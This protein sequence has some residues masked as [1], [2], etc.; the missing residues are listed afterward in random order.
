MAKANLAK[1]KKGS[2]LLEKQGPLQ[3]D[4][5]LH[6]SDGT[7]NVAT[8]L[9]TCIENIER[10]KQEIS[11]YK[12]SS[13]MAKFTSILRKSAASEMAMG[14]DIY[15]IHPTKV[16]QKIKKRLASRPADMATRLELIGI[17]RKSGKALT[18][19]NYQTLYL[20]ANIACTQ[21]SMSAQALQIVIAL[22]ER[23]FGKLV[24]KCQSESSWLQ[25]KIEDVA[26]HPGNEQ[27]IETMKKQLLA[28]KGTKA[29]FFAYQKYSHRGLQG[30]REIPGVGLDSTS[31][32][33]MEELQT[34]ATD[35]LAKEAEKEE[36]KKAIMKKARDVAF[37]V[38]YT[39]FLHA[40]AR[41]IFEFIIKLDA[42]KPLPY[43]FQARI[44]MTALH[45]AVSHYQGEQKPDVAKKVQATFRETFQFYSNAVSKIGPATKSSTDFTI[46]IEF[47]NLVHYYYK[48]ATTLLGI[49]LPKDWLKNAFGKAQEALIA[50]HDSGK[51]DTLLKDIQRDMD[52]EGITIS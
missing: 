14:E 11:G 36:L 43:F 47:S 17:V 51:A 32:L 46:L 30:K 16:A 40:T 41:Q 44:S 19:E 9:S 42:E 18:Y 26:K 12:N 24:E 10:V 50:A 1:L 15:K 8:I 29:V 38:R 20:Q 28:L 22:Q 48:I 3:A 7:P 21:G 2:P 5:R 49:K 6:K 25:D 52:A 37:M 39:P 13:V 4:R 45:F 34:Y 27:Q 35:A 23:F 33:S 31:I